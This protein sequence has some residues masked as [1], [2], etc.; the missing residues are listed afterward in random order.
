MAVID[1]A[2]Q[3]YLSTYRPLGASRYDTHKNSELREVYHNI[4]KTNKDSPLYMIKY[5]EDA[6]RFAIDIKER[7]R[8]I[9]NLIASLSDS[10]SGIESVFSKKLAQSS[11]ET[12][13]DAEYIGE[14]QD[15]VP[16][17]PLHVQVQQLAS[18]QQNL[19]A[20]LS[21][22]KCDLKPGVYSFDLTTSFH[23]YEFQYTAGDTDTNLD[24][25]EKLLRLINTA[26]V[27]LRASLVQNEAGENAV[28]IVSL[29]TGH[30]E[31]EE[32]L[33]EL[34]P[35]DDAASRKAMHVLGIDHVEAK[36]SNASF[37]LNGDEQSSLSNQFMVGRSFALTFKNTNTAGTETSIGFKTDTDAITDNIF[38]LV[39]AY[40]HMISLSHNYD[41]PQQSDKLRRDMASVAES[42]G[43][44][45]ESYGFN[46]DQDGAITIDRNLLLD[47]I[48]ASDAAECF[49]VLNHFK[50]D[51]NAKAAEISMNPLNYVDKLLVAYKNPAR[52]NFTAPYASCAY[53]GMMLDE[54][55]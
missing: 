14:E 29:Q 1:S 13:V 18:P 26:N 27:G 40:N 11:D 32:Y 9:Q 55:C 16:P 2:Y 50:D 25:Q 3:Y 12:I 5:S 34:M 30:S 49:S 6:G 53:S 33:F 36:A 7:T 15:T 51:L 38:S 19:G 47:S 41:N 43:N 17:L 42:Y 45:L 44:E 52:H 46:L 37:L 22:G 24:I 23:S 8:S 28:S 35:A 31:G 20:Y 39:S 4:V 48:T 10:G 21:P 54:Y